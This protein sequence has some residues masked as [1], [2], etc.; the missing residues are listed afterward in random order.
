MNWLDAVSRFNGDNFQTWK[1]IS[2]NMENLYMRMSWLALP[3]V[4]IYAE[5]ADLQGLFRVTTV[6]VAKSSDIL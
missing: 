3:A 5:R 6:R 2:K 4:S 1:V